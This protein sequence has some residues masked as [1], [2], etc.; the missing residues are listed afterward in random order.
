MLEARAGLDASTYAN[1]LLERGGAGQLLLD[2]GLAVPDAFTPSEHRKAVRLPQRDIVRLEA[3]AESLIGPSDEAA[4]WLDAVRN[5]LRTEVKSGAVAVKAITAYR[6]SLRLTRP[7][8]RDVAA[9][10]GRLRVRAREGEAVRVGGDALCHALLW[11]AA[12]ECRALGVPLQ[13]HTGFG[14]PDEDLAEAS[15]LGLR[16]LLREERLRGLRVVLLHTY[17]YHRE[18]AYL[19]SVYPD[20]YMDLSLAIPLAADDGAR[21]L[22]EALGLCPWTKLL[23]AT[24]ASRLPELYFVAGVLHRQALAGALGNLVG[25]G[26]LTIPQADEA[27]RLVLA[28][29]ARRIYRLD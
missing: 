4:G 10:Y 1:Q 17:P 19:C 5:R 29:N 25:D 20:V 9:A 24:D 16:P 28:G 27:G 23:Y 21:A 6:A 14:D 11:A 13:L 7:E 22:A 2:H 12:E 8:M 3:V 15:P 18:A 26:T